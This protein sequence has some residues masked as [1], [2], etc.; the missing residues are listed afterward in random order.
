MHDQ[1]TPAEE[2]GDLQIM[3]LKRYWHKT[4]L[5]RQGLLRTDV[6]QDEWPLDK[7][8][9]YTLGMGLEQTVIYLYNTA[10]A[11]NEFERWIIETK[12]KPSQQNID[13]FNSIITG[14][15]NSAPAT[16]E[17][18]LDDEQIAF[19]EQNGY[20]ILRNAIPK[21]DCEKTIE[22]ICDFIQ[23]KRDDPT[24]WYDNPHSSRQGIMVQLFQDP[25]LEKNRDSEK[26]RKAYEQLYNRTDIWV[27]ADRVGFNPPETPFW[28]FPGPRLHWDT[29]LDLP[30]PFR[31]QGLLYLADTEENQGAF[32][33]VPGFQ[34]RIDSWLGSL[35]AGRE[36]WRENLYALGCIPVAANAG[37]FII[38]HQALPHGSSPNTSANP[39]FVQYFTYEP[40]QA[41]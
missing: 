38:W 22:T 23:I 20:L 15:N 2:T 36:P 1:L 6:L 17:K 35:P 8:L 40:A 28:K 32:S 19:W 25:I 13:R 30:I 26:I 7:A 14:Q 9:L 10:P 33:L 11:F 34:N 5:M 21:E 27:S 39:R 18:V 3:Q 31:L 16:I 24:T 29:E 12:G 37:D 41:D 4:M